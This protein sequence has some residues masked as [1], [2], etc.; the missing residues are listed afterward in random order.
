MIAAQK[1]DAA[2]RRMWI[3]ISGASP[4][5]PLLLVAMGLM[6]LGVLIPVPLLRAVVVLPI[7]LLAP[8]YALLMLAF[9]DRPRLDAA[10]TLALGILLSMAFYPL[11]AL[12]LYA[13]SISLSTESILVGT[14]LSVMLLAR[15]AV[16]RTQAHGA[17]AALPTRTIDAA[18]MPRS[19]RNGTR[20]SILFVGVLSAVALSLTVALHMLPKPV[21]PPYTQFYLTGRWSQINTIAILPH[22]R[23]KV[24]VGVT[25]HTHKTRTYR[26]V[27]RFDSQAPWA[28]RV[29]AVP[30]DRTWIGDVSGRAPD[31]NCVHRL[32]IALYESGTRTP[33]NSLIV[34]TRGSGPTC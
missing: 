2:Y 33:L 16:W 32:S 1:V 28:P 23:L 10:S 29:V 7:A 11:L 20:G 5:L 17:P 3:N 13:A 6:N 26:I 14:D 15:L 4:S 8:G 19:V 25:N 30:A 34:W 18:S 27:A 22:E 21:D 9:G 12:A 24:S 31:S